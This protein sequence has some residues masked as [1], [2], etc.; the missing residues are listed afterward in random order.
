MAHVL[1]MVNHCKYSLYC[2]SLV[3]MFGDEYQPT[4]INISQHNEYQTLSIGHSWA[5]LPELYR[6]RTHIQPTIINVIWILQGLSV[7]A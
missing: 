2:Q 7:R 5:G 4:L 6:T 3:V 1:I